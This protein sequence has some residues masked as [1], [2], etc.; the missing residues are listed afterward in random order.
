MSRASASPRLVA[1]LG[2]LFGAGLGLVAPLT[3][4]QSD[5]VVEQA[6]MRFEPGEVR[7]ASGQ[8]VVFTNSDPFGHNVHSV[9]RGGEFD[10]GLQEPGDRTTVPFPRPGVFVV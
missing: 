3:L 5:V 8:R 2:A 10:I 9:S 6:G 7:I 4:A 1:V